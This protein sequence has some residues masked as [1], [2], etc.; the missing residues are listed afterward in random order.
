M[1]P[2]NRCSSTSLCSLNTQE[3]LTPR[4]RRKSSPEQMRNTLFYR[5]CR[6]W[7][8]HSG[9]VELSGHAAM[10][11]IVLV[12]RVKRLSTSLFIGRTNGRASAPPDVVSPR[13]DSQHSR[14]PCPCVRRKV[15]STSSHRLASA[16]AWPGSSRSCSA[17]AISGGNAAAGTGSRCERTHQRGIAD[18]PTR[19]RS[20]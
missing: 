13:N 12:L 10:D 8:I 19:R 11:G 7:R 14:Q 20:H 17:A 3:T 4:T 6:A 1:R 18:V 9:G 2:A 15:R 16:A 5:S